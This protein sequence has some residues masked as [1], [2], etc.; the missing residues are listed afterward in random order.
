MKKLLIKD[1]KL[2]ICLKKNEKLFFILQNILNNSNFSKFI[3]W[4]AI[5]KL[6]LLN[7]HQSKSLLTNRC[8]ETINKK[9]FNKL[10]IY[11][12]HLFLKLIR[13]GKIY[14]FQKASW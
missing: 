2:R 6:K 3:R 8:V 14:G 5:L 12:R 1:K 10:T 9:R 4:K 7:Y 11:S 13:Q